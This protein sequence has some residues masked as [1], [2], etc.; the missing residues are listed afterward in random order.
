MRVP[1]L[2]VRLGRLGS[3][4]DGGDMDDV[5]KKMRADY[6]LVAARFL[7]TGEW[8]KEHEQKIGAAIKGAIASDDR[9]ML[10]C[11][12]GWL[13]NLSSWVTAWNLVCRGSELRMREAVQAAASGVV[14]DAAVSAPSKEGAA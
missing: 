11:W 8:S 12:S 6:V 9:L 5:I 1:N 2:C 13:A 4:D 14:G 7:E 10:A 3:D